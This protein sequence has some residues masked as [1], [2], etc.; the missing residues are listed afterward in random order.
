VKTGT[1]LMFFLGVSLLFVGTGA[2]V[3]TIDYDFRYYSMGEADN[4]PTGA[5][6]Y[7]TMSEDLQDT[8]D[9]TL[10]SEDGYVRIEDRGDVPPLLVKRDGAYYEFRREPIRDTAEGGSPVAGAGVLLGVAFLFES[11]RRSYFKR[12]LGMP[13]DGLL[14]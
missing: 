2:Y 12:R 14:G 10:A 7:D 5:I 1:F 6:I 3:V 4:D 9:A 13:W 8:V 11:F